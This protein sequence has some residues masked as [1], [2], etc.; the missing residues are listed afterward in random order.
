[1]SD[2]KWF[3]WIALIFW[4]MIHPVFAV[5]YLIYRHG[6]IVQL[7]DEKEVKHGR[8]TKSQ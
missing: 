3:S 8:T 5:I 7:N 6:Q 2:E 4:A 1:M